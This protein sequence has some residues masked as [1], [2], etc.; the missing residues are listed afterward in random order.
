MSIKKLA[1][2][3]V[4][5]LAFSYSV[6]YSLQE[7]AKAICL[8]FGFG[9]KY[10]SGAEV[11]PIRYPVSQNRG[12]ML[13]SDANSGLAINAYGGAQH[14][15]YLRLVNNCRSDISDCT[16]IYSKGMLLSSRNPSLAI[17]AY[18]GAQ[19]GTYLRLVNN[20][21]PDVP[22]CTWTYRNGMFIS[23]RNPNLAINAYG[24]AQHG[25]YLRLV[26][27]CRADIPDCTWR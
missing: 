10:D 16:W 4:S 14:G 15:T 18:G 2:I 5:A 27:N 17:N 1:L 22:D 24:G 23:S 6:V 9:C 12:K 11:E 21:R 8:P 20:C 19:H 13:V 7:E 3:T 25:T 26:N